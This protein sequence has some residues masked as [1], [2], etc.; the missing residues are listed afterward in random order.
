VAW[1][2]PKT[3]RLAVAWRE[4][5][6]SRADEAAVELKCVQNPKNDA[7]ITARVAD[8]ERRLEITRDIVKCSPSFGAA[9]SG[10][11]VERAWVNIHAAE[12]ALILLSDPVKVKAKIS[13]ILADASQVLQPGDERFTTLTNF[14]D[15]SGVLTDEDKE[16]IAQTVRTIY[17]RL[18]NDYIRIRSFR[19]ILFSATF[20]LTL[21]A[22]GVGILGAL[23]PEISMWATAHGPSPT[24]LDL[25]LAEILGVFGAGLTG[26][27]AIRRMQGSSTPYRIP[28]A[29]LLLKLP[30]GALTAA[31]GLMLIRA[32]YNGSIIAPP[33]T[34]QL[35]AYALIFGAAQQTI[36]S[37]IDTQAQKV[38]KA[39]P[40]N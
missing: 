29:S 13:N 33:S 21:M 35:V 36:T 39:I 6:L 15:K 18:T 7:C 25:W 23:R 20:V 31:V 5:A 40:S 30:T 17:A 38:L 26:S 19:N 10:V 12:V 4:I 27:V 9:W 24:G 37:L 28:M 1:R 8:A 16:S 2:K 22:I 11:D 3:D 32:A 34:T 14:K